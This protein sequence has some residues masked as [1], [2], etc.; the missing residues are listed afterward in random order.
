MSNSKILQETL[1]TVVLI[2]LKNKKSKN[3]Y[4]GLPDLVKK[5][6]HIAV[7]MDINAVLQQTASQTLI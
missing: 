5:K 7:I 4:V 6:S 2:I 1:S 3:F